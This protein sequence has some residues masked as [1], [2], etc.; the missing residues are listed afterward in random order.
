MGYIISVIS[1]L[2]SEG[3]HVLTIYPPALMDWSES[4]TAGEDQNFVLSVIDI[5][6][7]LLRNCPEITLKKM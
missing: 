2:G 5:P 1:A 3:A 7:R 4:K 6:S